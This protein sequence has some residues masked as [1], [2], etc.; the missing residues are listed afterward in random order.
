ML[1]YFIHYFQDTTY[2]NVILLECLWGDIDKYSQA[3]LDNILLR[4][5]YKLRKCNFFRHFGFIDELCKHTFSR[6]QVKH[7][8][9]KCR[10]PQ[11]SFS[12][13]G[14]LLHGPLQYLELICN[15]G[16]VFQN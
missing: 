5:N 2:K 1:L 10:H 13:Q 4:R 8:M 6:I 15:K 12:C 11:P 3:P 16:I 14:V 7:C 9:L